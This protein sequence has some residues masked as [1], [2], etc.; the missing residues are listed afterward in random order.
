MCATVTASGARAA[1]YECVVCTRAAVANQPMFMATSG[2]LYCAACFVCRACSVPIPTTAKSTVAPVQY[3]D[4]GA[5]YPEGASATQYYELLD[6]AYCAS[7][8]VYYRQRL[9]VMQR[10]GCGPPNGHALDKFLPR[11]T[12]VSRGL[13][14]RRRC[15]RSMVRT[16][17]AVDPA[18]SSASASNAMPSSALESVASG[19]DVVS[20]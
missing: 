8:H 5:C 7:C 19:V 17:Q 12:L 14:D 11:A 18:T 6:E 15:W 20:G 1:C 16:L 13:D 3:G 4:G 9:Y 2:N 10:M